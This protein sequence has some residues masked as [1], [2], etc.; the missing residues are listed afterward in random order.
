[1]SKKQ[2]EHICW[3]AQ[4]TLPVGVPVAVRP[5][6]MRDYLMNQVCLFA[7]LVFPTEDGVLENLKQV[8]KVL[9]VWELAH[10]DTSKLG[11]GES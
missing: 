10:K 8:D 2:R 4:E 7:S 3:G 1:M 9:C 6:M 11:G 5:S